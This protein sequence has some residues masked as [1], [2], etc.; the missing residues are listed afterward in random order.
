YQSEFRGVGFLLPKTCVSGGLRKDNTLQAAFSHP[1]NFQDRKL[2][3][4][5]V[6]KRR[7]TF[8]TKKNAKRNTNFFTKRN[9]R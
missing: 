7:A 3:F 9:F 6:L 8:C 2:N 5:K 1:I 4:A